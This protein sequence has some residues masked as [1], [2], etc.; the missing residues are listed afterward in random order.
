MWEGLAGSLDFF[1][2]AGAQNG[3]RRHASPRRESTAETISQL[4]SP[5]VESR[6]YLGEPKT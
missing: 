3:C 5:L 2:A 6:A 1:A 4:G